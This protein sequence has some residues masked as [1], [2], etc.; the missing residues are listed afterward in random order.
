M[1]TRAAQ[2]ALARKGLTLPEC[3][4]ENCPGLPAD[5]TALSDQNLMALLVELSSWADYASAVHATA[6]IEEQRC[7][8]DVERERAAASLRD[9][10]RT[11]SA[12]KAAAATASRVQDAEDVLLKIAAQRKLSGVVLQ[13]A[14][15]KASVVSREL[16]RRIGRAE[17][18]GR[19]NRWSP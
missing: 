4:E 18:D 15:R 7:E 6:S 9:S 11:V 5:L 12:R 17:R 10:G 3:P 2:N 14:E 19:V 16:T 1:S 8:L 13:S